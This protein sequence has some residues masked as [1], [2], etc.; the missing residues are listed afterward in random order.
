MKEEGIEAGGFF[1]FV[2]KNLV[3]KGRGR[4]GRRMERRYRSGSINDLGSGNIICWE[5]RD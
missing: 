4:K 2:G 5:R 1:L 3:L